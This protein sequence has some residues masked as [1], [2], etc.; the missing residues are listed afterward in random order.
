MVVLIRQGDD[1]LFIQLDFEGLIERLR[2]RE[3][4]TR[5]GWCHSERSRGI[6]RPLHSGR[7]DRS[8]VGVGNLYALLAVVFHT[9]DSVY[10]MD[11]ERGY[12]REVLLGMDAGLGVG[13][14][15]RGE[16]LGL[17]TGKEPEEGWEGE[18]GYDEEG[19]LE[20]GV[21]YFC[22]ISHQS[23]LTGATTGCET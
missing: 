13:L 12:L 1:P 6:L 14:K 17:G 4:E 3:G 11:R 23:T 18:E 22:S 9:E 2:E 5:F 7:G 20:H 21:N 10:L 15:E 8:L 19:A 16:G